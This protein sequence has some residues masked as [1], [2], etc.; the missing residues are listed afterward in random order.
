MQWQSRGRALNA[1]PTIESSALPF[2]YND[3]LGAVLAIVN[4]FRKGP[5][6]LMQ[7]LSPES[8]RSY[9]QILA[10]WRENI[11]L[12]LPACYEAVEIGLL[13]AC[14][15]SDAVS[16]YAMPE[17]GV[18]EAD[19]PFLGPGFCDVQAFGS[20]LFVL[21]SGNRDAPV[22]VFSCVGLEMPPDQD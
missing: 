13:M 8:V 17:A 20:W 7:A 18:S 9:S 22:E 21:T 3:E 2:C 19:D 11:W 12:E 10:V 14:Q 6:L 4:V 16:I 5:R 15:S 1:L